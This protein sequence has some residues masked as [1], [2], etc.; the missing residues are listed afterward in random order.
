MWSGR[1]QKIKTNKNK[2][3]KSTAS[4][5]VESHRPAKYYTP[6][7][8]KMAHLEKQ[9]A[10]PVLKYLTGEFQDTRVELDLYPSYISLL[11]AHLLGFR[12]QEG[13]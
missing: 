13:I 3:P 2:E 12:F 1:G 7:P 11:G 8:T 5:V 6:S 10:L 4:T 9:C